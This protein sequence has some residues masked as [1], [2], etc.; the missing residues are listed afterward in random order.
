MT[1]YREDAL[2]CAGLLAKTGPAQAAAVRDATSV[3]NASAIMRDNVYG[4]FQ[5][6]GRG[7]YDIS[8]DGCAALEQ[9]GEVL[10]ARLAATLPQ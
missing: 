9:Y 8:A 4:W 6:V 3:K 5:K 10:R 7:T 2:A 1:A